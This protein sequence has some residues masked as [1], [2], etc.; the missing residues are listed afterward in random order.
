ML[1][2]RVGINT[3]TATRSWT[4]SDW[5][6]TQPAR[7]LYGLSFC[8][9]DLAEHSHEQLA[10]EPKPGDSPAYL[11]SSVSISKHRVSFE[12]H[13]RRR[14]EEIAH[15]EDWLIGKQYLSLV[16]FNPQ[17]NPVSDRSQSNYR[18]TVA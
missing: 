9:F 18:K 10:G 7:R 1:R 16:D 15:G 6:A 2:T 4:E 17:E 14:F 11:G 5:M 8:T 13:H 3:V 12:T